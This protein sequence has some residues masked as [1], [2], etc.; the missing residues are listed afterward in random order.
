MPV[1]W[2]FKHQNWH[3]KRQNWHLTFMTWTLDLS[4]NIAFTRPDV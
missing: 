2:L 3:F 4:E 1:F